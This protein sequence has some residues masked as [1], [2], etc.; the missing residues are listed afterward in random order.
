MQ[1]H[2]I[3]WN[4]K[5]KIHVSCHVMS[6]KIDTKFGFLKPRRGREETACDPINSKVNVMIGIGWSFHVLTRVM[7]LK[8]FFSPK[9]NNLQFSRRAERCRG[10][11]S[12]KSTRLRGVSLISIL[13]CQIFLYVNFTLSFEFTV[14]KCLVLSD[15]SNLVHLSVCY[16]YNERLLI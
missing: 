12:S 4:W 2:M 13:F 11:N 16:Y 15:L 3:Y 8:S 9:Y 14:V 1:A 7:N 6:W 5:R 10:A